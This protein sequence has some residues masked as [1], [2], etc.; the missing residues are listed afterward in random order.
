MGFYIFL[1]V[2]LL[3]ITMV[4]VSYNGLVAGR[5]AYKNAFAQIDVQLKRRHDLIPNLVATAQAYMSHEKDTLAAVIA[6]RHGAQSATSTAAMAPGSAGAMRSVA[7]AEGAL[8]ASLGKLMAVAEAYPELKANETMMQLSEELSSTENRIAFSRQAFND[9]VMD[10]N[11]RTEAFPS[12]LL[13]GM[14]SFKPAEL[15]QSIESPAERAVPA[16]TFKA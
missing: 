12:N 9:S 11:T 7:Q 5:N 2:L 3:V 16:V 10:Y 13:A 6:A 15:L 1:G 8:S 4:A 14:F